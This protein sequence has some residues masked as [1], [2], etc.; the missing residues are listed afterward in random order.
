MNRLRVLIIL[1]LILLAA[2]CQ[3]AADADERPLIVVTTGMIADATKAIVG[4]H[5]QVEALMGPGVD[6]HLYKAT[7]GDLRLLR[8][9]DIVIY[10]G[11]HLEGKMQ[12]VFDKL[13]ATTTV[14]NLSDG[15]DTSALV[16]SS[17][18]N[19]IPTYD[20]HIWFDVKLWSVAIAQLCP[21]LCQAIGMD[22]C[23]EAGN[24][25]IGALHALNEWVTDTLTAIPDMNSILI[26]S[27]DAFEY[28]GRAYQFEVIGLQGISTAAEFGL[29]DITDMVNLISE[30][31]IPAVFIESSVS[32]KSI[33]SVIEGCKSKGHNVA[34][35]G[36]LFSD[37][38]GAAGTP[39]GT[40]Q[41]MVRHNVLL[42]LQALSSNHTP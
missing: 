41:G 35:G 31:R 38:M 9:A 13:A 11:L 12:K 19:G 24:A 37:A 21:V 36:T 20:P 40:Y 39:E 29:K 27:H 15:L 2:S 32:E 22:S 7:Q 30:R 5:A 26:T 1:P 8:S 10:N 6:P 33:R 16:I 28:F 17:M 14:I 4:E 34:L 23:T 3:Q 25:Y 42:L 18:Q